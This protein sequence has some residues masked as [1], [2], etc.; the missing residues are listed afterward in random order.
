MLFFFEGGVGRRRCTPAAA[1]TPATEACPRG[2][3]CGGRRCN[4]GWVEW[5]LR[6]KW[7]RRR[8]V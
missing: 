5:Q 3:A 7:R 1:S 6:R 4:G 8:W 2:F